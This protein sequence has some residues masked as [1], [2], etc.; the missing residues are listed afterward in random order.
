MIQLQTTGR[1]FEL[2]DKILAYV[3]DKLG[4]LDKFLPRNSRDGVSGAVVL[5]LDESL[6]KDNRCI[7]EVII[8][9]KGERMV[10]K[11]ATVNMYA[12]IDICEQ[13]VKSQILNYKSKHDPGKNRRQRL[14]GKM[15]GRDPVTTAKVEPSE[16]Q[17]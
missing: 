9:V 7:C 8:E 2:D 10:A 11:E 15:V 14:F 12:A 3:H 5:E 1:H 4:K 16:D 6:T 13:K 17:N